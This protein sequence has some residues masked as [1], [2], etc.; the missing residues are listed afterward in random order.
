M[1]DFIVF[2]FLFAAVVIGWL[3]GHWSAG[4]KQRSDLVNQTSNQP[5]ITGL[6]FLLNDQPDGAIDAFIAALEVNSET[7]ETHLAIGNLSRRRGETDR[8]I[9]VH[10]NLLARPSLSRVQRQK[11][12]FELALDYTKAG[13]LDRAERIL[14]ELVTQGPSDNRAKVLATLIDIYQQEQ[15]WGQALPLAQEY[16][17]FTGTEESQ[18]MAVAASH[19]CCELA[20]IALN[21]QRFHD[22]EKSLR[23]ALQLSATNARASILKAQAQ[24]GLGRERKALSSL[25]KM[26]DIAPD[27]LI[28]AIPLLEQ[29]LISRGSKTDVIEFLSEFASQDE[30]GALASVLFGQIRK[31]KGDEQALDYLNSSRKG[32]TT[33]AELLQVLEIETAKPNGVN[34][35]SLK[36]IAELLL[37][38]EQARWNYRCRQCGFGGNQLHWLCPGCKS[39]GTVSRD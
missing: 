21:E 10:Q 29:I 8:A 39:W 30:S 36:K 32:Q 2:V 38:K 27:K 13:W 16:M 4:R 31:H 34:A 7:I 11:V 28:E 12:Q 9:R 20:Q 1:S 22:A 25:K 19:Y 24:L 37:A 3:L 17:S 23:Q 26:A 33:L 15:E 18:K 14:K 35:E 6:N 5:Y